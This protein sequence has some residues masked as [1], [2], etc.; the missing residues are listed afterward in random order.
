MVY[1]L[2]ALARELLG[3]ILLAIGLV[4]ML[5]ASYA[6]YCVIINPEARRDFPIDILDLLERRGLRVPEGLGTTRALIQG[7]SVA[8]ALLVL[9]A[10]GY[11][12]VWLGSRALA[13]QK[14]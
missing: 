2:M 6:A 12:L 9:E 1:H 3:L 7:V 13:G 4:L 5:A 10:I 8:L 14:T 11:G